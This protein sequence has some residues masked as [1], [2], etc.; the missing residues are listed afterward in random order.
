VR[1]ARAQQQLRTP[2]W[3]EMAFV[4]TL[5]WD[6]DDVVMQLHPARSAYVNVHPNVLHLW[7]PLRAIIPLPPRVM[8]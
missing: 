4:K 2:T 6:A 8:V 5:C 1:R 3:D 7:R